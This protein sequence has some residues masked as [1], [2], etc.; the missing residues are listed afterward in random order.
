M[1]INHKQHDVNNDIINLWVDFVL[2]KYKGPLTKS[3]K[4]GVCGINLQL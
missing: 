2:N 1:P 4:Y 3:C